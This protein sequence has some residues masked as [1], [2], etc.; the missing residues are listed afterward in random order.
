MGKEITDMQIIEYE[1]CYCY[2]LGKYARFREKDMFDV[3]VDDGLD[4]TF[5]KSNGA[6][7]QKT[8]WLK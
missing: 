3:E 6:R 8:N 2:R 1:N 5:A 4:V 7:S